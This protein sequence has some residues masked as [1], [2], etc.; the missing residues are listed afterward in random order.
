M[1]IESQVYRDLQKHLDRLPIR[2]PATESG[3]EIRILKH[4]F[5]PEEA[6]IALQ[7]SMIPEPVK[8]IY[9]RVKKSGISI[10]ELQNKL[11]QMALKGNILSGKEGDEKL[12]SNMWLA[13]G[14][15]EFQVDRLTEDFIKDITQYDDEAFADAAIR[16]SIPQI[17]TIPMEKSIPLPEK[18]QVSTYDDL[19]KIVEN[20]DNQMAVAN[21]I[22]RQV[23]DLTGASCARTDLRETCLMVSPDSAE[24]YINAG[25]G[26]AVTKEEALDILDKAQ[27]AGLVIQPGNSQ[28]PEFICC[29]CGDC[30]GVLTAIKKSPRPSDFYATNYYIEVDPDLCNGCEICIEQCQLDA[31]EMVDGVAIIN[32]D[33]CIGCGNC[34][35]ICNTNANQLRKKDK[36]TIPPKDAQALYMKILSNRI[37]KLKLLQIGAK[38]LLKLKV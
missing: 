21:C 26:R 6:K 29:C 5:T 17:R 20:T 18:Y 32:L 8:R 35:M 28:H 33:R 37:S 34:V 9:R 36:E 2:Y 7:L 27:E 13:I 1:A 23:K 19:R 22:C 3:V 30:C 12:Y 11:D 38:M 31:R 15:Y 4:L 16:I 25:I 10:E 24:Y 14:M